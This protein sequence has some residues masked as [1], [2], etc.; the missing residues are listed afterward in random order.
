MFSRRG[1]LC[2]RG[3]RRLRGDEVSVRAAVLDALDL[4][5]EL[6]HEDEPMVEVMVHE[7]DRGLSF[8]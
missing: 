3:V 4:R 7:P 2:L 5:E 8:A 6:S 1:E